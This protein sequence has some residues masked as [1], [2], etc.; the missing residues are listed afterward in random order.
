MEK[1]P[2]KT[3]M[4]LLGRARLTIEPH[5]FE[6][7]LYG[8]RE[9]TTATPVSHQFVEHKP[10]IQYGPPPTAGAA[11]SPAYGSKGGYAPPTEQ[12]QRQ[13][14]TVGHEPM[15]NN[16][17]TQFI[18]NSQ[19]RPSLAPASHPA[20]HPVHYQQPATPIAPGRP[21]A[22]PS[23]APAQSPD[24][25]IHMLAQRAGH[26]PELKAIMKIV[27]A[28]D[29]NPQQLQF[30][31]R[32]I[33]ELT[34]VLHS[35][36]G[37]AQKPTPA[38][39][40]HA[41]NAPVSAYPGA[42]SHAPGHFTPPVGGRQMHPYQVQSQ[43]PM[44]LKAKSPMAAPRADY[45]SL[46][47]EFVAGSADRFLF[48]KYSILE[49]LP[50]NRQVLAS[51]LIVRKGDRREAGNYDPNREYYQPV[52]VRLSTD[53]PKVLAP[54]TRVVASPEEARKHMDEIMDRATRADE[55]HLALRLPKRSENAEGDDEDK[56][57]G[58]RERSP[59]TPP[60]PPVR[61]KRKYTRRATIVA[62]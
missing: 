3:T 31:Q 2:A 45:S 6:V 30:F 15:S 10:I 62:A 48:P 18:P 35:R 25:V 7:I 39:R 5:V 57:A 9:P 8:V 59:S 14:K 27:A 38:Q 34:A 47:F 22:P 51:F 36:T 42:P 60:A 55:V 16:V 61:E 13:T 40:P 21:H 53:D 29:A 28:G 50:G 24:P 54:L 37:P 20:P 44:P 52:T 19:P 11:Q 4:S 12:P 46:V 33:D 49:F 1:N 23:Q 26:D 32:H 41:N 43:A 56:G 58:S 17:P